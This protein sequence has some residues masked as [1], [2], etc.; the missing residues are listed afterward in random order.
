MDNARAEPLAKVKIPLAEFVSNEPDLLI[1]G[2]A[3]KRFQCLG[4]FH[5]RLDFARDNT[6]SLR[7]Y[8]F[9]QFLFA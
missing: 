7:F 8:R 5:V 4:S 9:S 1:F 2:K 6:L 3:F